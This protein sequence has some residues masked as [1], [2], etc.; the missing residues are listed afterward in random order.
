MMPALMLMLAMMT[1]LL[2]ITLMLASLET[3]MLAIIP[4]VL[5]T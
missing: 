5:P 2:A 4:I 3:L 1:Q